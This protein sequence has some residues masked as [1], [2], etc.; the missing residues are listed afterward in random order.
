MHSIKFTAKAAISAGGTQLFAAMPPFRILDVEVR[1]NAGGAAILTPGTDYQLIEGSNMI[2]WI[3]GISIN[4]VVEI[5]VEA[6]A[7]LVGSHPKPC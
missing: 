6:I 2:T 3:T 4:T 5:R 1:G 7:G